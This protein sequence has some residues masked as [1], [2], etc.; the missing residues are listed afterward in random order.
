M[1]IRLWW[2]IPHQYHFFW[3]SFW[4]FFLSTT[5]AGVGHQS[6]W[7]YTP[8]FSLSAQEFF[9]K[10]THTVSPRIVWSAYV[11]KKF[12]H[13]IENCDNRGKSNL[14]RNNP[15]LWVFYCIFMGDNILETTLTVRRKSMLFTTKLF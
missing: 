6:R 9:H 10:Y 3:I 14:A 8:K 12:V 4:I 5:D 11:K 15:P 2:Y 7:Q 1:T 13:N